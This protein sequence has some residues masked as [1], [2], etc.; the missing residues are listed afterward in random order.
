MDLIPSMNQAVFHLLPHD[1]LHQLFILCVKTASDPWF[2]VVLSQVCHSWRFTALASPTLWTTV[3]L[4]T[5]RRR[6]RHLR[7]KAFLERS[8]GLPICMHIR[9]HRRQQRHE[10]ALVSHHAPRLHAL[11]LTSHDRELAMNSVGYF[12]QMPFRS[13]GFFHVLVPGQVDLH[14]IR[15]PD[16]AVPF[17][18]PYPTPPILHGPSY[19]DFLWFRWNV[20]N[21]TKLILKG[22]GTP[23]R[24]S[25]R[26][27]WKMLHECSETLQHF[28]FEGWAP[29][30]D[31]GSSISPIV[32]PALRYLR[33]GYID[34]LSSLAACIHA[35]NLDIFTFHDVL[36]CP[37]RSPYPE[38]TLV[39]PCDLPHIFQ[40]LAPS[41]LC[42]RQLT[43]VGVD[44]C[45]RDAVDAFFSSLSELT[46]LILSLCHPI[47]SD[48]L[49]QPEA[50]YR[51]PKA[52]FPKLAQLKISLSRPTDV[53]RFLLRH[54][55]LQVLPLKRIDITTRQ[56]SE[57]Y[58]RP[59]I[60]DILA[61]VLEMSSREGVAVGL[62]EDPRILV[63]FQVGSAM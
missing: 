29:T 61:V 5:S 44:A 35:P 58:G 4:H 57:A 8:R 43:L 21:V 27:L 19:R 46:V 40:V 33:L 54:K 51:V 41:C 31:L 52:I 16:S 7:P 3:V 14:V 20:Q 59:G 30:N 60:R 23:E 26:H 22:L 53:A 45:A 49:F 56:L 17:F 12:S 11:I 36:F 2:A 37:P 15:K 1:I 32:L 24:P 38:S 55:T 6:Q 62:I 63:D 18:T 9:V 48:A 47:F 10:G 13:L 42:L 25:M 39:T 50:R 34:D 28:D